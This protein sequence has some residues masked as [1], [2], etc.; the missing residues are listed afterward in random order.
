MFLLNCLPGLPLSLFRRYGLS[1]SLTVL[2][3]SSSMGGATWF[4]DD[5]V[6]LFASES[7]WIL[8]V[9]FLSSEGIAIELATAFAART[10]AV[11]QRVERKL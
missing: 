7:C 2:M 1:L 5:L 4:S 8:A 6:R 9:A 11:A 10:C 3:S